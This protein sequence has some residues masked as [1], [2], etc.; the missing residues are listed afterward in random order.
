[1]NE[2]THFLLNTF[3]ITVLMSAIVIIIGMTV[4][5]LREWL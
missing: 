2:I 4:D 3:L 5:F 1:M